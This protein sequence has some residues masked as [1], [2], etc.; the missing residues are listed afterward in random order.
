MIRRIVFVFMLFAVLLVNATQRQLWNF[1]W[2][3]YYGK[4]DEAHSRDCD[5]SKWR[6]LDLP[7]DFQIEQ[8][9]IEPTK[10]QIKNK[11]EDK[12]RGFKPYSQAWYRKTFV[13][14]PQWKNKRVI[15]DFEGV[16]QVCDV[17]INGHKVASN[18][19][20]Y[21]GFQVDISNFIDYNNPNVIAVFAEVSPKYVS[22]WY[23]GGGI[24]RNVYLLQKEPI[25]V[26]RHGLYIT[27]PQISRKSAKVKVQTEIEN[28]LNAERKIHVKSTVY[29]PKGEKLAEKTQ[30]V[31]VAANSTATDEAFFDIKNPS[32]WDIDSPTLYSVVVQVLDSDKVLDYK[33]S[34]FGVRTIEFN[35][36]QGFLL[37]G[38]KVLLKGS[39]FHHDLG[40]LG[41]AVYD[42]EIERR[43][44]LLKSLGVNNIRTSHNPYSES[45]V[46]LADKHGILVVNEVFDKWS[47]AYLGGRKHE[48]EVWPYALSEFIKRDRN[49]P[50][51]IMWSLGNELDC[52]HGT[53]PNPT[54]KYGDYAVTMYRI[55]RDY[56]KKFD[57][58]RPYT[59]GQFPAREKGLDPWHISKEQWK[60]TKPAE[61]AFA[62]DVS[63]QNYTG[64]FFENDS[65]NYPDMIFYQSEMTTGGLAE[66]FYELNHSKVAGAAYW[67]VVAYWGESGGWP[68]KGWSTKAYIDT[69]LNI[70]PQGYW[71]KAT[72]LDGVAPVVYVGVCERDVQT[73]VYVAPTGQTIGLMPENENW[74]RKD[75]SFADVVVYTNA[76][77]A[78]LFLNGKSLGVRKNDRSNI[79]IR[80]KII[81]E[82]VKFEKGELKA[83]AKTNGKV[84]G[85]HSLE[86][87]DDPAELAAELVNANWRAD[88][89]D[90]QI[91]K[92]SAV[93]KFGRLYPIADN[94]LTFSLE[95]N[96]KLIG[97]DNGD[98]ASN[99]LAVG[100]SR[101]LYCGRAVAILRAGKS[102]DDSIKLTIK[103]GGLPT[104]IVKLKT[105]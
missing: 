92:I 11:T 36:Q 105:K 38:R 9:F 91:V 80:N 21:S 32:L 75:G 33:K 3:F 4:N 71:M 10:E 63:S 52:Q 103:A 6:L 96:A 30:S 70:K 46:A 23:T 42:S 76:D 7:H 55:K 27:T 14:N 61:L 78:E 64:C 44:L 83:V 58:T 94:K 19:Y 29:S 53:Y 57:D 5:D 40:A 73:G 59:V 65:K 20:G 16:M 24:Y 2:K 86:S 43:I 68:Q 79:R 47:K 51:V 99:E 12:G 85:E 72:F 34:N 69:A 81:W 8:P 67:G 95:G 17:Y 87:A 41:A 77:E 45:F 104:K 100:N 66:N 90:L 22:R 84:V 89:M 35:P 13:A 1:D 50:S 15:V 97:V 101:S 98:M 102:A 31:V 18:E 74:N 48:D 49:H 93:D 28:T 82:N 56:A 88:G 26:A 54:D 37:N 62:T 25:S 39:N 60:L